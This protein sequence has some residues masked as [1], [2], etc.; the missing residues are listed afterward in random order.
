MKVAGRSD[1]FAFGEE[2]RTQHT[3]DRALPTG[4]K[5]ELP[6]ARMPVAGTPIPAPNGPKWEGKMNKIGGEEMVRCWA[7]LTS[8]F[9]GP[10]SI[11]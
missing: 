1:R 10:S 4:N 11:L 9:P 8:W 3:A 2:V 5:N 6:C 7:G